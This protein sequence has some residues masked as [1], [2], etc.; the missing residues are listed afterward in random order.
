MKP[1]VLF[2][3]PPKACVCTDA[4]H[5]FCANEIMPYPMRLCECGQYRWDEIKHDDSIPVAVAMDTHFEK[6]E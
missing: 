6:D 3:P 2:D 1:T 5:V 4:L